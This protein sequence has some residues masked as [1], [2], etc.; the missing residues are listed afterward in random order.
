MSMDIIIGTAATTVWI[1][2]LL[3]AVIP[4][5]GRCLYI[6]ILRIKMEVESF[7]GDSKPAE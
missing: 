2:L 6:H 4:D 3:C 1:L 7:F 5:M